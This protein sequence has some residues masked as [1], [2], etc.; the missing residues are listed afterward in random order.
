MKQFTPKTL[1]EIQ[2]AIA[3]SLGEIEKKYGVTLKLGKTSYSSLEAT[4][5]IQAKINDTTALMAQAQKEWN[6]WA[7]VY[8][9]KP[10]HFNKVIKIKGVPY[11]V[12]GIN[13]SAP[14]YPVKALRISDGREFRVT[15]E[16]VTSSL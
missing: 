11:R 10:E 14:K 13:T 12:V 8:G 7:E 16:A 5:K 9:M 1:D 2:N 15:P 4:V 6:M 3:V